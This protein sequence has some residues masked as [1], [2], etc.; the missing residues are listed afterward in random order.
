MQKF[1]S[2]LEAEYPDLSYHIAVWWLS[3]CKVLS[4]M[5]ELKA[6]IKFFLNKNL[7]QS[8]Q[9]NSQWL[10]RL[11]FDP[12]LIIFL[13]K[14]TLKFQGKSATY[15]QNL[16]CGKVISM[17]TNIVWIISGGKPLYVLPILL[18]VKISCVSIPQKY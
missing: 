17:T 14:L 8:L 5:F 15:W 4:W 3:G 18:K 1:L 9:F 13:N 2:K 16:H 7:S 12:D 6:G 11:A 10:W